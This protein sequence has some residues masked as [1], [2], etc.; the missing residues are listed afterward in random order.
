MDN[1]KECV[2]TSR[3]LKSKLLTYGGHAT[4]ECVKK[5]FKDYE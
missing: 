2:K 5:L 3:M 4:E 1:D